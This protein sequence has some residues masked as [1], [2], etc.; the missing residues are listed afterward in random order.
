MRECLCISDCDFGD[1]TKKELEKMKALPPFLHAHTHTHTHTHTHNP[2][3]VRLG[4]IM[5]DAW[6]LSA[7]INPTLTQLQPLS[8]HC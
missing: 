6:F 7:R 1:E 3:T 4:D 5:R 2:I 8:S